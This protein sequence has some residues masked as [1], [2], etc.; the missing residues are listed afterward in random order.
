MWRSL[1]GSHSLCAA[2]TDAQRRHAALDAVGLPGDAVGREL[3]AQIGRVESWSYVVPLI[4]VGFAGALL[5]R[6]GRVAAFGAGWVLLSF[7]G[8]LAIYWISRNPLTNH[9]FNT[10]DRTIDTLLIGSAL[11]VPV[12]LAPKLE[13]EPVEL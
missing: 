9:L 10:S 4:V 3:L 2:Y 12:L 11:L 7:A 6:R 13:P 5:L 1:D 8:L